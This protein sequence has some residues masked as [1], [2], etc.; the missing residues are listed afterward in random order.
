MKHSTGLEVMDG[1]GETEWRKLLKRQDRALLF[2][3]VY[4]SGTQLDFYTREHC[5]EL[6]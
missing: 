4:G 2:L 6:W 3:R 1:A 5:H